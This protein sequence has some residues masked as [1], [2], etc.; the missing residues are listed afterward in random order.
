VDWIREGDLFS[1]GGPG[2]PDSLRALRP[3]VIEE[4]DGVLRMWYSGSDGVTTRILEAVQRGD[5]PWERLGVNLAPGLTGDSDGYGV[6]SPCV[7][8]VPSGYLMAYGGFDGEMTR[9]HMATSPDGRRWESQGT[10][11]QRGAEDLAGAN[12]PCLVPTGERW[13]LF[14]T[15]YMGQGTVSRG[16]ILGAVSQT[17]ASWDRV[18][19]VLGPV[20]S[21]TVASHP[22][23][24]DIEREFAMFYAADRGREVSIA[25]ATSPDGVTW[26]RRGAVLDASG[27]ESDEVA[28]HTPCVLRS[29]DGSLRIWFAALARG[30]RDAAYRI[31]SARFSA[32][33]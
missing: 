6:E 16:A 33:C 32:S 12:H 31:R 30:D 21:E 27:E 5:E 25:L 17:G 20:G 7:V 24:L 14:Y 23:V 8:R 19:P 28:V 15:G 22:C 13:W 4:G 11:L 10:I 9:L 18:G 29:R 3:W 26:D 1:E 2:D